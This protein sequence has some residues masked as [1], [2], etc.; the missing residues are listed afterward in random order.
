MIEDKKTALKF[1]DARN[2]LD[3]L[4]KDERFKEAAELIDRFKSEQISKDALEIINLHPNLKKDIVSAH[5]EKYKRYWVLV[6]ELVKEIT[7]GM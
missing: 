4:F 3:D 2:V 6:D 7:S 5:K 1:Y